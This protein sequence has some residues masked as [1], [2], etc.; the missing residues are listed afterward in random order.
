MLTVQGENLVIKNLPLS[1]LMSLRIPTARHIVGKP[2]WMDT[3]KWDIEAKP[4][5]P[6]MPSR[7]RRRE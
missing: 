3:D 1:F 2:G 7:N 6:G 4:D 5:T